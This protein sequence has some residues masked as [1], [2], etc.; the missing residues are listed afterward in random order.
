MDRSSMMKRWIEVEKS[1][2]ATPTPRC[3]ISLSGF[4]QSRTRG[5]DLS[6][7]GRA[8][9]RRPCPHPSGQGALG[10]LLLPG[11]GK[12]AADTEPSALSAFGPPLR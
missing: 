3:T 11:P 7:R 12:T 6:Q 1:A 4:E 5:G 10:Y 8:A 2:A 9:G